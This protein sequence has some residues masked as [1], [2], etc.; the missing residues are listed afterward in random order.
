MGRYDLGGA[1]S[2]AEFL[3]FRKHV[4]VPFLLT[5]GT[6]LAWEGISLDYVCFGKQSQWS[7]GETFPPA[8][9]GKAQFRLAMKRLNYPSR[10]TSPVLTRK[11]QEEKDEAEV[12]AL[13][14]KG[15]RLRGGSF[16]GKRTE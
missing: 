9:E 7:S 5:D 16:G 11:T 12:G 3:S 6:L 8:R 10:S 14:P 1:S 13:E 2:S 4:Q 15:S